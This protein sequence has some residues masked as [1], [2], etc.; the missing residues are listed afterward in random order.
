[1]SPRGTCSSTS[2]SMPDYGKLSNRSLDDMIAGARVE[3]A[4]YKRDPMDFVLWKP[5]KPGEP[6][7]PSP[8]EQRAGRAG[9][10]NARRW[11]ARCSGRR[12]TSTA[13]ASTSIF[14][15]HENE[16]AQSRC[17]H[18]TPV[19]ANYWLHNGFLQVEGEKMSKTLGNFVTITGVAGD[20]EVRWPTVARRGRALGDAEDP[21]SPADRL[22]PNR[23][24][25]RQS[26]RCDTFAGCCCD[27]RRH[28]RVR[29]VA[30]NLQA[31]LSDDLNT[32]RAIA[33]LHRASH[34][35]VKV[36]TRDGIAMSWPVEGCPRSCTAGRSACRQ[37]SV[38]SE[39]TR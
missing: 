39:L 7:W 24:S 33:A 27:A 15:H 1:M 32:P 17:A 13:A 28:G 26:K 30:E 10:S 5:S 18:G 3:V 25:D 12:S 35:S 38:C 14:P 9:T 22:G 36:C 37:R 19:M 4:P 20:G 8:L 29:C 23:R 11:P 6:A 34:G 31:A 2:P 21:L 16:I